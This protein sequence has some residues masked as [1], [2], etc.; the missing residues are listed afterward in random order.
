MVEL[1]DLVL[2]LQEVIILEMAV[3]VETTVQMVDLVELV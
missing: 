1:M 3:K 2:E